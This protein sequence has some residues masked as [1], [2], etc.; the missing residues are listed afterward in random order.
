MLG[1]TC[2]ADPGAQLLAIPAHPAVKIKMGK[3]EVHGHPP[4][5]DQLPMH[6]SKFLPICRH[7]DLL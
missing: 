1:L 6:P 5:S 4:P 7:D 2:F 3:R